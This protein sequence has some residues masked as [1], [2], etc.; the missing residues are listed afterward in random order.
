MIQVNRY[1]FGR[2]LQLHAHSCSVRQRDTT[3]FQFLRTQ[4]HVFSCI[5]TALEWLV[6]N[7]LERKR[8]WPNLTYYSGISMDRLRTTTEISA[9]IA[10]FEPG[11]FWMRC[12]SANHFFIHFFYFIFSFFCLSCLSTFRVVLLLTGQHRRTKTNIHVLSGI[13][14]HDP[15]N[16]ADKTHASDR[17]A[18]VTVAEL[19]L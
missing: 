10:G 19:K 11:F 2:G 6:N 12:R 16:Q 1:K 9:K 18:T 14:T 5:D 3:H 13:R 17:T 8:S 15:S 4:G 7:E